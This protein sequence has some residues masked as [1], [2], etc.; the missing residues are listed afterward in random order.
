MV[1]WCAETV[2]NCLAHISL[3]ALTKLQTKDYKSTGKYPI[4]DQGQTFIAGWTDDNSGLITGDLPVIVFGDHTRALKFVDFPFVRGADGTQVLKPRDGIDAL[5]FYYACRSIDLPGRGYNRHFSILKQ[6]TIPIPPPREQ[7]EIAAVMRQV[8]NALRGQTDLLSNVENLKRGA[9]RELFK[10]GLRNEAQKETEIGLVPESWDVVKFAS[11]RQWLQY[12]TSVRC[13]VEKAAFP[14]LRIP[15]I[16]PG[17]VNANDLKHCSMTEK[18]AQNYRL[19]EG[20]L[21]FIRTNG[22]LDRLGSCAVYAGNPE[23]ALFASY[24]IRARL[25]LDKVIPR[26]AAFFFGSECG[27]GLVAGR[28]T[29]AADGKYN[30]NTGTIDSLPLPLPPALDEQREIVAILDAIDR[31]VDLHK[32]KRVLLE[33]LFKVLLHKLM[34]GEIPVGDL[35]LSV[36]CQAPMTGAA[37]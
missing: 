16:E 35:D 5:F 37:A 3:G 20:D 26:F 19:E 6:K 9:M 2:E 4:V 8:E 25:D 12:G 11:V 23:R 36:F 14:V 18:E 30:L 17:R 13:S 10:R 29:P 33:G 22:V 24:L 21:I 27:T 34:T 1:E 15:N 32:R 31:K 7:F 28:A